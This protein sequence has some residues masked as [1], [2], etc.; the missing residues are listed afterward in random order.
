MCHFARFFSG[1]ATT[2]TRML[3]TCHMLQS[4]NNNLQSSMWQTTSFS[5]AYKYLHI[6]E[7]KD[8][9]AISRVGCVWQVV[10]SVVLLLL[11]TFLTFSFK[12][13]LHRHRF[14][15]LIGIKFFVIFANICASYPTPYDVCSR[16]ANAKGNALQ[17]GLALLCSK[18]V[19]VFVFFKSSCIFY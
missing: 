14:Q 18:S 13:C 17:L 5:S 11:T 10:L 1:Y 2:N 4:H 6:Y 12:F 8:L 7:S 3:S 19:A 9:C 15:L 16:Q